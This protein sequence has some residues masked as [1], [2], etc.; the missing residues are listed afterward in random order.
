MLASVR[1]WSDC[2]D[3]SLT[4]ATSNRPVTGALFLDRN[5]GDWTESGR[6][7][8]WRNVGDDGA[9]GQRQA[10]IAF[11]QRR[12][13]RP[14]I[15]NLIQLGDLQAP[16]HRIAVVEAMQHRRHPPRKMLGGPDTL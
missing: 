4:R 9:T 15:R 12:L 2:D 10:N 5:I 16:V 11:R 13:Q 8:A 1:N 7:I 14:R 6:C 3:D